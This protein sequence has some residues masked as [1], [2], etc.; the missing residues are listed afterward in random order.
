MMG[1]VGTI[2]RDLRRQRQE[3]SAPK[4][5]NQQ[6]KPP[7]DPPGEATTM[8]PEPLEVV[9]MR[10]SPELQRLL[11][12]ESAEEDVK[13]PRPF[14]ERT[15]LITE[16]LDLPTLL[17]PTPINNLTTLFPKP[18]QE[19]RAIKTEPSEELTKINQKLL[20][21]QMKLDNLNR[22]PLRWQ[23]ATNKPKEMGLRPLVELV[24]AK[25]KSFEEETMILQR[26]LHKNAIE[27]RL[28]VNNC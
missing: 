23:D 7:C 21:E 18:F 10:E 12:P 19:Q 5:Q 4:T 15:M 22:L 14:E 20:E 26:K 2:K 8:E 11:L 24:M 17:I 6:Q 16:S 9:L 13:I 25:Y 1:A 3:N 28:Y 27:Q